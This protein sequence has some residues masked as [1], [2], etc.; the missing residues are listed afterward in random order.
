MQQVKRVLVIDD[1][2]GMRMTLAANLELEGYEV[3][4][5]R[6]GAHAL[7]LAERQAFTLVLSDV[8]MPGLNGVETF[9]ELKRIQPELT[10]VL[11]TA[12]ALEQL[13]EEAI[14]E[15]VYTVIYKPFSMDHLARVVARA[16]DA[17][18]VLVV[19][20]IPK[21]A[22]SIVA[23]LRAAGLSAHAVHDGRTAVQH[24]LERRVDVCVLDLV[25]PDQDGVATCAQMRGLKKRVTVIA[26]TGHSVPEMV[27]AIMSQ[28]GYTCLR[29]PFDARELIHT[30]A[31]AR[32]DAAPG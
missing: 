4:E 9:R 20:D 30:I 24:V 22:D 29:K 10:V 7:E 3:V 5:A 19:D 2:E 14:A 18:A 11:M 1:E 26:M 27:G 21:V 28:G 8:R 31:R 32:G 15:G 12:F 13:I 6:D 23:V 16:V 17:P 25:M